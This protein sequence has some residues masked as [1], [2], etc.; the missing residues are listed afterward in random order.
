MMSVVAIT[1]ARLA[2][3]LHL[4]F[5]FRWCSSSWLKTILAQFTSHAS[6]SLSTQADFPLITYFRYHV[7]EYCAVIGT[8]STVWGN[9]LLYGHVPDP[10]PLCGT[11]SGSSKT[12]PLQFVMFVMQ[13]CAL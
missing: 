10:F 3:F 12:K 6:S 5:W 9:K 7:T 11:G 4:C 2:G 1:N 13:L 8:H